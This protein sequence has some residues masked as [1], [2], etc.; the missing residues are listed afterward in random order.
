M[1]GFD[2]Y[3]P[4][5]FARLRRAMKSS[6]ARLEPFRKVRKLTIEAAAGH[7]Y[8]S[9][10]DDPT[11]RRD[12]V[13]MLDQWLQVLVRSFV[14]TNPKVRVRNP[15]DPRTAAI[16]Q[17]HLNKS[18]IELNLSETLRRCCQEALLGYLGVAHCGIAPV[19]EWDEDGSSFCRP[20]SG[21]DFVVDM[22]RDNFKQADFIGHRFSKRLDDLKESPWYDPE[23]TAA[24]T[25]R[26]AGSTEFRDERDDRD[27]GRDDLF[28]WVDI[29]S[30][31]IKPAGLVVYMAE[32]SGVKQPLRVQMYDGPEYGPYCLLAFDRVL[33]RIMP[34]SRGALMLDLHEFV[35]GQYRK[36]FGKEDEQADFWTFEGG[37][38]EDARRIRDAEDGELLRV[39]NNGAVVRRTKGGT[40]PQ[41]MGVAIHGRQ[42]F[43]EMSGQ[44]RRYGGVSSI[45]DTATQA[46][47]DQANTSRLVKDMQLQFI[48]FSEDI[49][50][51]LAWNEWTHPSRQR[52]VEIVVGKGGKAMD[53]LWSPEMR[54]GDFV[55]HEIQ[56]IADSMEHRSSAQQLE[57][58]L[59]GLNTTLQVMQLPSKRPVTFNGPA[60][61]KRYAEMAQLPELG[62][63]AEF[64][65]DPSY[66][67]PPAVQ[68]GGAVKQQGAQG[69]GVQG[70][71]QQG[72]GQD[73]RMVERAL[74]M[75]PSPGQEQQ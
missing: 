73:E 24:L 46:R 45:A 72:M 27:S 63:F 13:N 35:N 55:E 26:R 15:S 60:F 53:A 19:D 67:T 32:D 50:R 39:D 14:Q 70:G 54:E 6:Y 23:V 69:A 56:I 62:E 64:A 17:E 1:A 66:V 51:V 11:I 44:I 43:D 75:T 71:E 49:L 33:D 28:D 34:N 74:S 68:G 38:E 3:D 31:L 58:M 40:N 4:D 9:E 5:Q 30:I 57:E 48:D 47:I 42:L 12:P 52:K 8:D 10:D 20:V 18:I 41:A 36:M 37:A 21:G 2:P 25:G 65:L 7:Y 16:Y 59:K 61:L 22:S 29:W